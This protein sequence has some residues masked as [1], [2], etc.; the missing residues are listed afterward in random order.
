MSRTVVVDPI[1]RIEG[2]LRIEVQEDNQRMVDAHASLG[3]RPCRMISRPRNCVPD[4]WA[5]TMR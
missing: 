4:A 1:T 5:S 2:H 3:S